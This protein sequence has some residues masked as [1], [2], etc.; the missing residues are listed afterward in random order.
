M[1]QMELL[2]QLVLK[3]ILVLQVLATREKLEGKVQQVLR[4]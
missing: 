3:V 2:V 1:V 4:D